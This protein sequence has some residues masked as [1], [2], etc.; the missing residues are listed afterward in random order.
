MLP[1]VVAMAG[2]WSCGDDVKKAAPAEESQAQK[3]SVAKQPEPEVKPTPK[4]AGATRTVDLPDGRKLGYD[5]AGKGRAVI[6]LAS[7]PAGYGPVYREHLAGLADKARVVTW[8]YG[9]CGASSPGEQHGIAADVADLEGLIAALEIKKPILLGHSYGTMLAF[10][11]ALENPDDV[12]GLILSNPASTAAEIAAA[13]QTKLERIGDG[14]QSHMELASKCLEGKCSPEE[15]AKVMATELRSMT[16]DD[17]VAEKV[18]GR[19][20]YVF[21]VLGNVQADMMTF[22]V[23]TDLEKIKVPTLVIGAKH[24]FVPV[25]VTRQIHEAI[26]GSKLEVFE[27][28]AHWPMV[29]ENERFISVVSAWLEALPD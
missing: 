23:R 20:E 11:F 6:V 24:D 17:A 22:D 1:V 19:F 12:S 4:V 9:G 2:V 13:Q 28:S 29:A 8:D 25:D 14:A 3:E 26:K 18:I 21:P 5:E 7:G 16:V 15:N 10:R 27:N